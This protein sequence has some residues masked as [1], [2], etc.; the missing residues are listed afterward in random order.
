MKMKMKSCHLVDTVVQPPLNHPCF[1]QE[2]ALC[3]WLFRPSFQPICALH[4]LTFDAKEPAFRAPSQVDHAPIWCRR[5]GVVGTLL[6]PPLQGWLNN[7]CQ[8]SGRTFPRRLECSHAASM[9]PQDECMRPLPPRIAFGLADSKSSR[10]DRIETQAQ[11]YRSF[12]E[13]RPPHQ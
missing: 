7:P 10:Q 1:H 9:K 12:A 5:W 6:E 2:R 3:F 13:N 4:Q 8:S 11:A